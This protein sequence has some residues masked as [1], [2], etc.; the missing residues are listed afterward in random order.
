[1]PLTEALATKP[2]DVSALENRSFAYMQIG[3]LREG[4]DDLQ[5]AA[6][7]GSPSCQSEL[8]R[9]YMIGIPGVLAPDPAVGI[10]WFKKSAAQGF[11]AGEENL[12]RAR[13]LFGDS[14]PH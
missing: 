2:S 3:R 8:G 1:M 11:A 13:Q 12:R 4:F 9:Y 5:A 14:S 10:E 6:Q 7:G